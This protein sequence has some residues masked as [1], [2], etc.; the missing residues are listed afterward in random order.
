MEKSVRKK[1]VFERELLSRL[2]ML[3]ATVEGLERRLN[4]I[5]KLR[6]GV[7]EQFFGL[8]LGIFIGDRI[9]VEPQR[10]PNASLQVVVDPPF[11]MMVTTIPGFDDAMN[12]YCR[13]G[14]LVRKDGVESKVIKRVYFGNSWGPKFTLIKRGSVGKSLSGKGV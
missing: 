1:S 7:R 4:S 14:N 2:K 12:P 10:N 11:E 3:N 6:D 5:V 8:R 13:A 9:R